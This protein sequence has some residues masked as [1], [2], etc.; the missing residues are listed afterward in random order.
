MGGGG[1][2]KVP[3]WGGGTYFFLEQPLTFSPE[4]NIYKN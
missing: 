2:K 1:E 3:S 4:K